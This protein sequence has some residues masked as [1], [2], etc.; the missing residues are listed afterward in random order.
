[1]SEAYSK[2]WMAPNTILVTTTLY[3]SG[4]WSNRDY[5]SWPKAQTHWWQRVSDTWS[6]DLKAWLF[7][8]TMQTHWLE[9]DLNLSPVPFTEPYMILVWLLISECTTALMSYLF[10]HISA[11]DF[12]LDTEYYKMQ[13]NLPPRM[14]FV[15]KGQ[16]IGTKYTQSTVLQSKLQ[17]C[18]E[19]QAHI[20]V[21]YTVISLNNG[22]CIENHRFM[23]S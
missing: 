16:I 22:L 23:L 2:L 20:K 6:S 1:M 19:I 18:F 11:I 7:H 13:A 14:Q 9:P 10:C 5:I 17:Q 21:K 8:Y 3:Q 4:R 15:E 12:T